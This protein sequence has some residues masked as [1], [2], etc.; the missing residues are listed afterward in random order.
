MGKKA[1][2]KRERKARKPKESF[3]HHFVTARYIGLFATPRGRDGR[4]YV[5]DH[6]R[7]KEW[8]SKPEKVAWAEDFYRV[9]GE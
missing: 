8:I 9:E 4:I 7:G 2:V 3:R 5:R 6:Q 1:R